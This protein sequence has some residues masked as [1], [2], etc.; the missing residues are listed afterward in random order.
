L[1]FPNDQLHTDLEN[2]LT[3]ITQT[4]FASPLPAQRSG[5]GQGVRAEIR[6]PHEY[7]W[8]VTARG[9]DGRSFSY[10]GDFDSTRANTRETDIGQTSAVGIFPDGV[11]PCGGLDMTG[12]V[13][14]WC[15]N[16]YGEADK[17]D[18]GGT[19]RR[20]LRGGSWFAYQAFARAAYRR[21][22]LPSLR[23]SLI[24]FRV[25]CVVPHLQN[26]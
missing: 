5:E 2:V 6:L 25:V 20:A 23:G 26:R 3:L 13:W 10:P 16:T 24:G 9:A 4:A 18:L 1:R 19:E 8:E 22:N 14:E 11:S 17:D 7:E 21:L 15:I 12:N